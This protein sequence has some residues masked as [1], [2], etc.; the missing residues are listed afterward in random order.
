M[1]GKVCRLI[2]DESC[3]LLSEVEGESG[4]TV[5]YLD[6]LVRR[7][8]GCPFQQDVLER[9]KEKKFQSDRLS[10]E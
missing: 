10:L 4:Q 8:S 5:K 9:I 2:P 3:Y 7:A 1:L 6:S